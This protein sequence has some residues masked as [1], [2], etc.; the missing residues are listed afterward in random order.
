MECV[1]PENIHTHP[2]EGN[3]RGISKPNLF[4]KKKYDPE[5]EFPEGG[6]GGSNQTTFDG[7]G[8]DILWNNTI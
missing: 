1:V 8:M 2:I 6:R 3:W 5:L 4:F 7:S